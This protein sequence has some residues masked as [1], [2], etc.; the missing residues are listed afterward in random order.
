MSK[1]DC[2][3]TCT[4]LK[5]FGM[6][7][8]TLSYEW[9]YTT[10]MFNDKHTK[11][12][13][14]KDLKDVAPITRKDYTPSGCT[15]LLDAVGDTIN[16]LSGKQKCCNCCKCSEYS[17]CGSKNKVMFVIITDGYE[18]AS[19]EF[20]KDQ[21]KKLIEDKTANDKWEFIFLGANIDSVSA[22]GNIG[23]NAKYARDFS[24]SSDGIKEACGRVSSVINQFRADKEIDLDVIEEENK[25]Q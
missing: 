5:V 14:R 19:R 13:N 8:L 17:H 22:A 3:K 10:V 15:A 6:L 1:T 11:I 20:N 18:N 21:V 4:S 7:F 23:I 9:H 12:Y 25:N 24:A 16:E 2:E